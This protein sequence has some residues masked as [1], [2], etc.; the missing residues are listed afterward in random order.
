MNIS[1]VTYTHDGEQLCKFILKSV[2]KCC[3][4]GPDKNL[5]CCYLNLGPTWTNVSNGKYTHDG[6]QLRKCILKFIHKLK[7]YGPDK[8]LTFSCDLELTK[9]Y[10]KWHN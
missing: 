1:E 7:S 5:T 8:T 6:E 2:H 9:K 4:Y 10:F 3:R